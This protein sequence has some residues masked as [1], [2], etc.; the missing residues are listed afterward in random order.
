MK[1]QYEVTVV[2]CEVAIVRTKINIESHKL[3]EY[4]VI[5]A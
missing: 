3:Y 1:P 5:I 4:E 2:K